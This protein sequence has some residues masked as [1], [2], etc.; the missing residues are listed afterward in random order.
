MLTST[1]RVVIL[2]LLQSLSLSLA[3]PDGA[4]DSHCASMTPAHG[5]V[6]QDTLSN[7]YIV[8]AVQDQNEGGRFVITISSN[9]GTFRGF[10]IEARQAGGNINTENPL[11][12]W[13]L[14]LMNNAAKLLSCFG[15]ATAVTHVNKDEKSQMVFGW[16]PPM[17]Y[18]GNVIFMATVV[19]EKT[20]F[21]VGIQSVPFQ[22]I[23]TV[24]AVGGK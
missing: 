12:T 15:L 22:V 13:D 21:W 8:N 24:A 1:I 3:H 2:L 5:V 19:Q 18:S 20:M 16:K 17:N 11:G 6:Q 7:P 23:E 4:P 14:D 9:N 10:L